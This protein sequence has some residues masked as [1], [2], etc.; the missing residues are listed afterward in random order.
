MGMPSGWKSCSILCS[1]R[2]PKTAPGM[3]ATNRN[4]AI[5]RSGSAPILSWPIDLNQAPMSRTQSFQK[6]TTQGDEGSHVKGHVEAQAAE[7]RIVP[8]EEP[9]DDDQMGRARYRD[10]FGEALDQTED[11]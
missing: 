4:Q 3:Q 5:L 8:A 11:D 1:K 10:E 7:Y 2:T 9:G 6:K